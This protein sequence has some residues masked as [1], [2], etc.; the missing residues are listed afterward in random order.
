MSVIIGGFKAESNSF[1]SYPYTL[2]H[3]KQ[4]YIYTDSEILEKLSGT[5]VGESGFIDCLKKEGY[6]IAP[7]MSSSPVNI[8]GGIVEAEAYDYLKNLLLEKIRQQLDKGNV[9]AVLLNLHGS[10]LADNCDDI[11]GE[12]LENVRSMVGQDIP[13]GVSLDCHAFVSQKMINNADVIVG[14]HTV[15]H[16][17]EYDTGYKAAELIVKTL[18][19]K[20]F[21]KMDAVFVPFLLNAEG[22][23]S[24]KHP[25]STILEACAKAEAEEGI[26]SVTSF[27]VQ[28]WLDV[29]NTACTVL[30]VSNDCSEKAQG[31][32]KEIGNLKWSLK[33]DYV[34]PREEPNDAVRRIM[35]EKG[36][37]VVI[38]EGADSPPA[39]APGDAN[40]LLKALL[41]ENVEQP[42][43]V[44]VVDP[45]ATYLAYE[46]GEGN[47]IKTTV[48]YKLD[49]RWG[50]PVEVNGII[51]KL[52]VG[53][54]VNGLTGTVT[55]YGKAAVIEIGNISLIVCEFAFNHLDP[56]SYRCMG[57]EPTEAR[58]VGVKSTQHFREFY[59]D[60]A[61]EIIFLEMTG[62]ST[63]A[64]KKL[65]YKKLSRPMWP[66]DKD[67]EWEA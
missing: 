66:I 13:I 5:K 55:N 28:P 52:D 31:I 26:E 11:E 35:K 32:A 22:Q 41:E 36:G 57:L 8:A 59:K 24:N 54:F 56:E 27:H 64:Y 50:D 1:S 12:V 67:M 44:T 38:T 45:E 40:V 4:G 3:F 58:I 60:I 62:A 9:E 47:E 43:Y 6:E 34:T 18:Q 23:M 21:P 51:K 20:I 48:G 63:N 39:G 25:Y 49:S 46:I 10:M 14:Y 53:E 30:V 19:N 61:E 42:A 2:D 7:T 17:D 33:Q 65:P 15:P 16:V 37:T 29:P